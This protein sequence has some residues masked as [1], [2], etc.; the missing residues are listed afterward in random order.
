M[1][2][3]LYQLHSLVLSCRV[4]LSVL[5]VSV[6]QLIDC[7]FIC[8]SLVCLYHCASLQLCVSCSSFTPFIWLLHSTAFHTQCVYYIVRL[9]TKSIVQWH[10]FPSLQLPQAVRAGSVCIAAGAR[11]RCSWCAVGAVQEL[12][13]LLWTARHTHN[14]TR[15]ETDRC[16][17]QW[18]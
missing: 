11:H 6:L 1:F 18:N 10:Q 8:Y 15:T 5:V 7:P 9:R 13:C 14:W 12:V 3:A 16:C 2:D 17:C 4:C